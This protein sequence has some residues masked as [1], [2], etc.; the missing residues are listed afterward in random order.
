[1]NCLAGEGVVLTVPGP[2]VRCS[3]WQQRAF[4]FYG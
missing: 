1:L 4:V 3:F 2:V